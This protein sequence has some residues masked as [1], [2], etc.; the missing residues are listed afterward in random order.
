MRLTGLRYSTHASSSTRVEIQDE[1]FQRRSDVLQPREIKKAREVV[2][3]DAEP[4]HAGPIARRQGCFATAGPP[5]HRGE[6]RQ[7]EEH[8]VHD[9]RHGVHAVAVRKLHD[10]RLAAERYGASGGECQPGDQFGV[11]GVFQLDVDESKTL[12]CKRRSAH[13]TANATIGIATAAVLS[14]L[15]GHPIACAPLAR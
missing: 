14:A 15:H 2:T 4:C 13:H 12:E 3:A 10:D 5:S 9:E 7:R 8:A 1:S 11:A 6:D